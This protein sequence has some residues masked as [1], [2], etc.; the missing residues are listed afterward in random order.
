MGCRN[1]SGNDNVVYVQNQNMTAIHKPDSAYSWFRLGISLALAT[2]GGIGLWAGIVV[3]PFIQTEFGVDRAGASFPYTMTMIGFAM[4]GVL[5]GRLADRFGIMVP[6]FIG[7]I[8]L[9][10]GFIAAAYAPTYWTFVAAQAGLIGLFG[11][12]TTFGPL[13]ADA[14]PACAWTSSSRWCRWAPSTRRSSR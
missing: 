8:M 4:G 13:V 12:A 5:M 9:G 11:C 7:S 6:M 1:K 2:I 14:R 10:A 3:L